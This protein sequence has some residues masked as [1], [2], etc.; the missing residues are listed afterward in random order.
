MSYQPDVSRPRLLTAGLVA[1][2]TAANAQGS[3]LWVYSSTNKSSEVS[4]TGFFVG[5]GRK[6]ITST[7]AHPNMVTS[8]P[9]CLGLAVGDLIISVNSTGVGLHVAVTSS[10]GGSTSVMSSTNGWDI[11]VTPIST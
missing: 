9:A 11:S 1:A 6:P 2:S 8:N 3:N 4:S 10:W 5:A 7:A